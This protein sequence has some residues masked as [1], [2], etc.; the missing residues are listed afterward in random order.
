MGSCTTFCSLFRSISKCICKCP[1][2]W[3]NINLYPQ[4]CGYLLFQ[5]CRC[6]ILNQFLLI[7]LLAVS[8]FSLYSWDRDPWP[9][10]CKKQKVEED[11]PPR[12][13]WV[14]NLTNKPCSQLCLA[15][16]TKR[17]W[18][19]G[20]E[21]MPMPS[22]WERAQGQAGLGALREGQAKDVAFTPALVASRVS[23]GTTRGP[24][25]DPMEGPTIVVTASS[26]REYFFP[27]P[28]THGL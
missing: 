27:L 25:A 18:P 26:Q 1:F 28:P 21:S 23:E 2:G 9:N 14:P 22:G 8:W 19:Q 5:L 17:N 24:G 10:I 3:T 16:G 13:W 12:S 15:H 6:T 7:D 4:V 20:A 11:P